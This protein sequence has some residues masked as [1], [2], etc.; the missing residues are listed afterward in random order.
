MIVLRWKLQ[1]KSPLGKPKQR[2]FDK[3]SKDLVMLGVE[4]YREVSMDREMEGSVYCSNGSKRPLKL[5]K[6]IK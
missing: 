5:F 6:K 1:R 3:V 4:N 2:W